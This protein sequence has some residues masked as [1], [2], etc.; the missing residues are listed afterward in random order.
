MRLT[1]PPS[2]AH[3]SGIF[4]TLCDPC[5]RHHVAQPAFAVPMFPQSI[6]QP[7]PRGGHVTAPQAGRKQLANGTA[8][9]GRHRSFSSASARSRA[10]CV[11]S[12]GQRPDCRSATLINLLARYA[13]TQPSVMSGHFGSASRFRACAFQIPI[14]VRNSCDDVLSA[15]SKKLWQK[16]RL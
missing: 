15:P 12:S 3:S 4:Q 5:S 14:R 1:L 11:C 10:R 7:I 16:T 13:G 8:L 9:P 2:P 6:F